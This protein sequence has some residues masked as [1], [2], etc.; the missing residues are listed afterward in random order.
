MDE[1]VDVRSLSG[2]TVVTLPRQPRLPYHYF[3]YYPTVTSYITLPLLDTLPY[4][5]TA[6][7]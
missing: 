5:A 6:S 4:R 3:I 1:P 2:V 7:E